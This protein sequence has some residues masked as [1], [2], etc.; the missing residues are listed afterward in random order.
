MGI[1]LQISYL[2][3]SGMVARSSLYRRDPEVWI[4]LLPRWLVGLLSVNI[5]QVYLIF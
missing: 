3:P 1:A 2:L 5:P 4:T